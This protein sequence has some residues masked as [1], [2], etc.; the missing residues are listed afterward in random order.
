LTIGRKGL[1]GYLKALGGS[2]IVKVVPTNGSASESQ[3]NG[4]KGLK[5]ICGANTSYLEANEWIADNT[6]LSHCQIRVCPNNSIRPNIGATEL[7]EAL[8]R[9]LPFTATDDTRPILQC[10]YF[11]AKEGK[12][13]I[14][15][16]D[17]FR[18][19]LITLDCD[20]TEGQAL[21]N[22][23]ELKG[24][25]NALKRARRARVAFEGEDISKPSSLI[26]DTELIRYK[27][28]SNGG[29]YPEYDK[30]IP[31]DFNCQVHFDTLEALTAVSSLKALSDNIDYPVDLTI[32]NGKVILS[33]PDDKGQAEMPADTDGK[34]NIRLNG[35]YLTQALRACGGMVELKLTNSYSPMLFSSNHN[36]QLVIMPM[37]TDEANAQ[38]KKDREAKQAEQ[39]KAN[40]VEPV[41]EHIKANKGKPKPK[42]KPKEPVA[43]A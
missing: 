22:N 43:V 9:V 23:G 20:D 25:I 37:L 34:V 32:G 31:S 3:A 35:R 29:N 39:D 12:L 28:Q 30:L 10:V 8:S 18:L 16:A 19:A 15:S 33:N 24:I 11:I 1:L 41:T 38:A 42:T 26:I 14:V 27:W 2:N 17:G 5:V 4:H 36:Y 7:S 6:P 40:K 21:I 13:T